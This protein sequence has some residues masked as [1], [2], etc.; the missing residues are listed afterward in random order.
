MTLIYP[1]LA[2]IISALI[3]GLRINLSKGKVVNINKLWTYTIGFCMFG[4]CIALSV[5]YYDEI[6]PQDVF[7]YVVYFALVRGVIYDPLLNVL[8]GLSVDYKSKTTNSIIDRAVGNRVNFWI[9]R[10]IY[11]AFALISG[12]I[13]IYLLKKARGIY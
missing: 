13:W 3:E 4:V 7:C 12:I 5:D 11:F 8:R 6:W 9:L 2:A 1:I 10:I